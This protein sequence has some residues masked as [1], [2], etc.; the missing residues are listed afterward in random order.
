M[1]KRK[2][3]KYGKIAYKV[4]YRKNI[5]EPLYFLQISIKKRKLLKKMPY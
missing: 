2:S 3:C 4:E 1:G 5:Y